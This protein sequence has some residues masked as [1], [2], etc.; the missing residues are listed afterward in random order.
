MQF[1]FIKYLLENKGRS[2]LQDF[3]HQLSSYFYAK[4]SKKEIAGTIIKQELV[5][6]IKYS[7]GIINKISTNERGLQKTIIS[8]S[9]FTVN[10]KLRQMGY[11]VSKSP[12]T[13][14][15][16]NVKFF[17]NHFFNQ[18]NN[19]NK[20]V[21]DGLVKVLSQD[22][23][24]LYSLFQ[25]DVVS[26]IK[27]IDSPAL[28]LPADLTFSERTLIKGF[29]KIE[30]PSFIFL[31]GMPASYKPYRFNT[32]DYLLV[33]GE[34]LKKDYI[35]AGF[36]ENKI[37][38]VGHPYY[39]SIPH[40]FNLR[41]DLKNILIISKSSLGAQKND[42][43]IRLQD[44]ANCLLYLYELQDLL[45][46]LDVSSVRLR[47]HPSEDEVW[48]KDNIDT[49][50]FIIDKKDLKSSME[51]ASLVIGPKSTVFIEALYY[52]VNYVLYEPS[53]DGLDMNNLELTS[54]FYSDDSK[55]PYATNIMD[56]KYILENV[57]KVDSSV[58]GE[59]IKTPFDLT[60]VAK[61]IDQ[62]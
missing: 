23:Y 29:K 3:E 43:R 44:N 8:D 12:W 55:I 26:Y 54:P 17:N 25:E 24:D 34:K 27:K 47:L 61:I 40:N 14:D 59:Y 49:K 42:G 15:N 58:L 21:N 22:F 28:I 50:F 46:S 2:Y 41:F 45:L 9:Y 18:Y 51:E 33:W 6:Y 5:N 48:Y 56:L 31:H 20:A 60:E 37:I 7:I 32:T 10:D 53:I 13:Y 1:N 62:Y 36:N 52:G 4:N 16:A 38:V 11:S 57:I 35:N 30:K 19:I 39:E